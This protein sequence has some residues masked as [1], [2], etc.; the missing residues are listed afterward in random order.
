MSPS[1]RFGLL[2]SFEYG[3]LYCQLCLKD[4]YLKVGFHYC[5]RCI[6]NLWFVS[7]LI[8]LYLIVFKIL[9]HYCIIV[10]CSRLLLYDD[11]VS[12]FLAFVWHPFTS[13]THAICLICQKSLHYKGAL[14]N[15]IIGG[16]SGAVA[17]NWPHMARSR[18]AGWT[19]L[20]RWHALG[21]DWL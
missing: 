3:L 5:N 2:F 4:T 17:G 7:C 16:I 18:F 11:T 10:K 13:K 19:Q 6:R 8:R 1:L 9:V 21:V 14:W 20:E 12:F 15:V